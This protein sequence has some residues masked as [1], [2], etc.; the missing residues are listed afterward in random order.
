[1]KVLVTGGNGFIGSAVVQLLARQGH[2]VRCLLRRASR[3]ERI[4]DLPV[5][6]CGGDVRDRGSVLA[7]MRGCDGVIHLASISGW[8]LIDSPLVD[9]VVVRGTRNVLEA[10]QAV[11]R[12]RTVFV[13]SSVTIGGSKEPRVY[14]EERADP[15]RLRRHRYARAKWEAEGLCRSAAAG[16]LPVVTVNPGEVYGPNDTGQITSGN[17]INFAMQ[18]PVLT[19]SGGANIVYR[20]DAAAGIVAALEQGRPGERYILGGENLTIRQLA[21]LTLELLGR[22][23]PVWSVPNALLRLAAWG[24]RTFRF[25]LPFNPEVIPYAVRYWFMDSSKAR[26]EFGISFRP[27]RETLAPTI[28]WLSEA[29]YIR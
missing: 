28:E 23:K 5:E 11:G 18:S 20:D 7:G 24:G 1:M 16:G 6:R 19:C 14:T 4:D 15:F 13:S 17:L 25:P 3:T 2:E 10:A 29:G 21:E 27:A 9:E 26:R 12:P 8:S 22:R